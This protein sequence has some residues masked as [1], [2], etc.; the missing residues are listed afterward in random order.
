MATAMKFRC[1]GSIGKNTPFGPF[2]RCNTEFYV[3][4]DKVGTL[5]PK[6]PHCGSMNT[7]RV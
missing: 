4:N 6:C 7:H 2:E 5:P 3:D 1:T